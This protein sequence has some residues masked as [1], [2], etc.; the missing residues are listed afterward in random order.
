MRDYIAPGKACLVFRDYVL[1]P[2]PGHEYSSQAAAYAVAANRV[3]RYQTVADALFLNQSTWTRT[4]NVWAIVA[5]VLTP[6][7]QK[8][9]QAFYKDPSV[10]AEVQRDT[11]TGKRAGLQKTPTVG[12][13][14]G[15]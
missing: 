1:P 11:E 4:G 2:V 9:V 8:K 12:I 6:E 5:S 7:E 3:G 10:A 13:N 14:Y 15:T